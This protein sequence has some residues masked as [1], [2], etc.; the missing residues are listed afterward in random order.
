MTQ[1]LDCAI[2]TRDRYHDEDKYFTIPK[3]IC[4]YGPDDESLSVDFE[5][6][7]SAVGFPSLPDESSN[8]FDENLNKHLMSRTP[9]SLPVHIIGIY[10]GLL[11]DPKLVNYAVLIRVSDNQTATP[12][13]QPA[14]RE[15]SASSTSEVLTRQEIELSVISAIQRLKHWGLDDEAENSLLQDLKAIVKRWGNRAARVLGD[16]ISNGIENPSVAR[17]VLRAVGE[18]RDARTNRKRLLLL[19]RALESKSLYVRDGALLGLAS[20]CSVKS[21]PALRAAMNK[22]KGKIFREDIAQVIKLIQQENP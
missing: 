4:P 1:A 7:Y 14:W 13:V 18:I 15:E 17:E 20:M 21:L 9:G 11:A 22:E 10:G 12:T 5:P 6:T 2:S 8:I 16:I 3:P 19:E